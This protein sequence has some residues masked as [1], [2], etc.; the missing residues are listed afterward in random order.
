MVGGG[1]IPKVYVP[2]AFVSH[3]QR[4]QPPSTYLKKNSNLLE[5]P[6]TS[7]NYCAFVASYCHARTASASVRSV[8][9]DL[10]A[11]KYKVC[12]ALGNCVPRAARGER[13]KNALKPPPEFQND[14][15]DVVVEAFRKYKFAITFENSQV[16]YYIT[17]KMFNAKLAGAIP[18]YFG[19][20][21]ILSMVN[22]DAF[23]F[24]D[25]NIQHVNFDALVKK[26]NDS[27]YPIQ[28]YL[29]QAIGPKFDSCIDA[30][31]RVDT[32]DEAYL[33]MLR[34]PFLL[35]DSLWPF[36]DGKFYGEAIRKMLEKINF[37]V[38]DAVY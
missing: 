27:K 34:Q 9:F 12:E 15:L 18:I 26:F 36:F 3:G 5:K 29:K 19:T 10:L 2:F 16:D 28:D 31:R 33:E 37:N 7:R 6:T 1:Y 4:M 25:V 35:N 13:S 30:V 24:C 32:D 23:I 22:A 17:E 38:D 14:T 20:K 11:E 8:F 21:K